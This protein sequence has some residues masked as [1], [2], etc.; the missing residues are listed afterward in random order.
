ML[1]EEN[2]NYSKID[3]WENKETFPETF[4]QDFESEIKNVVITSNKI[5]HLIPSTTDN[6]IKASNY[7]DINRLF[8]VTAFVVR[9]VKNLFRKVKRDNLK[10]FNYA[11][12][13][14]I[15]KAKIYWI[16]ANQLLL[17]RNENYE[18][19]SKNLTLKFDEENI[20]QCY[21]CP[22]N[23]NKNSHPIMLSRNHELTKL[24]VIKMS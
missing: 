17:L 15:Y 5:E 14:E 3:D 18:N 4:I 11:Y 9:F 23:R 8:R 7:I 22:E 16:K 6:I 12:A 1:F 10:L 2:Q 24:I 13:S 21:S 20:I 19:L